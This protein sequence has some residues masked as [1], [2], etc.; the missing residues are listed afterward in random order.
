MDL[1][2]L[3]ADSMA[4]FRFHGWLIVEISTDSGHVGIGNARR[5]A[6]ALRARRRSVS[7]AAS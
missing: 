1:L 4:G 5:S 6:R 3:P 2:D 7:Q